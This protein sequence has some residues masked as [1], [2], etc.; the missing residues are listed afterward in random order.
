MLKFVFKGHVVGEN[1]LDDICSE[2]VRLQLQKED[3]SDCQ[4]GQ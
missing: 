2:L 1:V 3:M 4:E